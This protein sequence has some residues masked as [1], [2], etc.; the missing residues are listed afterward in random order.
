M[1]RFEYET[2]ENTFLY[3]CCGI[4]LNNVLCKKKRGMKKNICM[5]GNNH[6]KYICMK[7]DIMNILHSSVLTPSAGDSWRVK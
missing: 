5:F 3:E 7:I 1:N 2:L 4:D 6:F